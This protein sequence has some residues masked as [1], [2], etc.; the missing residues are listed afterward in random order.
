MIV[1]LIPG[2]NPSEQLVP[3]VRELAGGGVFGAVVVVND[4][5]AP[6]CAGVFEEIARLD[7]VR[8]LPHAVNLGKGA[9]LKTGLNHLYCY[10]PDFSGV[11]VVDADGQHLPADAVKVARALEREPE[12]L[13]MGAR[14]FDGTVPWRSRFGNSFTRTVFRLLTGKKL[15]DTQS[16][17]RGIPRSMIP[18]LLKLPANGYEFELDMLLGCKY[19]GR[20]IIEEPIQTVYLEG[21][22]SSHF[23]PILDSMRIYFVLFRFALASL[24][25]A[26]IDYSVFLFVFHLSASISASQAAARLVSMGVNYS[27]V[28]KAVFYSDQKASTTFPKYLALVCVSGLVSYLLIEALVWYLPVPVVV[29]KIMAESA[30]FLANFAIQRDFIFVPKKAEQAG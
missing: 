27:A 26:V 23:N 6:E 22:K 9:A 20:T 21:N 12:C 28:K 13:V 1:A 18:M 15:S 11:V 3:L 30:V 7:R 14:A 29:A 4:G 17:L 8:V 5:S 10:F 16:G 25:S 2:F 24:L 19:T